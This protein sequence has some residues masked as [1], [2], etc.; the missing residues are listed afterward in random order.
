MNNMTIHAR[1]EI[2]RKS[3]H[4][5]QAAFGERIGLR[6]GAIGKMERG[7]TV[8]DQNIKLIC[9]KFHIRRDWLVNGEGEMA[10][11]EDDDSIIAQLVEEYKLNTSQVALIKTFL[12]LTDEQR[13]AIV[14]AVCKAAQ[15]V[16]NVHK[17]EAKKEQEKRNEAHRQ[18]DME[19][20]AEEK[21]LSASTSGSS[22]MGAEKE[23]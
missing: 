11:A 13:E 20:D 16:E 17:E 8:T 14:A 1:I 23:A 21:G 9:E 22:G 18:L 6:G 3:L 7:G 12:S 4:L 10:M 15:A 19:L 5:N 2:L